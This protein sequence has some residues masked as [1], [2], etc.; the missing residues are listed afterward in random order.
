MT[1]GVPGPSPRLIR[2]AVVLAVGLLI[3][4]MMAGAASDRLGGAPI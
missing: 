1:D 3:V 4:V 2:P